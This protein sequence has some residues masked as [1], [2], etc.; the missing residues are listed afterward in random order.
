MPNITTFFRPMLVSPSGITR[1]HPL[2]QPWVVLKDHF[3]VITTLTYKGVHS[4]VTIHGLRKQRCR[5]GA[6]EMA[7]N[8]KLQSKRTRTLLVTITVIVLAACVVMTVGLQAAMADGETVSLAFSSI[9]PN[10]APNSGNVAVKVSGSGFVPGCQLGLERSG[11]KVQA[12]SVTVASSNSIEGTLDLT[13]AAA[14]VWSARVVKP[15]GHSIVLSNS[16]AVTEASGNDAAEPNDTVAQAYGPLS[17]GVAFQSY[18]SHENDVDFFKLTVP[19]AGV[20]LSATMTSIPYGCDYDLALYN[21]AGQKVATSGNGDNT[22]E[23]IEVAGV[24]AGQYFLEVIGYQGYSVEDSYCVS[25][26]LANPPAV[27]TLSPV[28]AAPGATVTISGSGF[29]KIKDGSFVAFGSVQCANNLYL[30]WSANQ[31]VVKVPAGVGGKVPVSIIL[32]SGQKSNG[33]NFNIVPRIDTLS[34]QS[35]RAGTVLTISGQGFG[36]WAAGSTS[37]FFGSVKATAYTS[38]SNYSVKVKVPSGL[39]GSVQVKVVTAGGTS[40]GKSFTVIK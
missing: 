8:T 21:A 25:Y 15:D 37:V 4:R 17:P 13:G 30:S 27:N 31:V 1:Y 26:S 22:D 34:S 33:V 14:G 35:G 6:E 28:S 19:S 39:S 40:A 10:A 36:A 3:R 20:R 2:G 11:S 16:F 18:I 24:S 38:W 5:L 23:A 7:G 9:S 29:G 32:G 12:T